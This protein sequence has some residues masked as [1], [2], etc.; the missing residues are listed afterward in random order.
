MNG[1]GVQ[2]YRTYS[3]SKKNTLS[4]RRE[5]KRIQ[6][7]KLKSLCGEAFNISYA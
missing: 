5:K 1:T 7:K 4:I 6:D 2:V 3:F